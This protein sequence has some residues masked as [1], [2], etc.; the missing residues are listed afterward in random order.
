MDIVDFV[1]E[2]VPVHV[3]DLKTLERVVE[4]KATPKVKAQER[5]ALKSSS[6]RAASRSFYSLRVLGSQYSPHSAL[7]HRVIASSDKHKWKRS[8]WRRTAAINPT[9]FR[10]WV[11][12]CIAIS[13]L[14]GIRKLHLWIDHD[15]CESWSVVNERA[16]LSPLSD[17]SDVSG[18]AITV[19]LPKLHPKYE[20]PQRH[21]TCSCPPPPF[22]VER[23][24]RREKHAVLRDDGMYSVQYRAGFHILYANSEISDD[25]TEKSL[26]ETERRERW[27]WENGHHVGAQVRKLSGCPSPRCITST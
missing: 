21:F 3:A 25:D 2:L 23:R 15:G 10:S 20:T 14:P 9:T 11:R 12:S 6:K 18:L 13:E 5:K 26:E 1:V 22:D 7:E 27:L 4:K 8:G 19:N 24:L 17:L 16:I